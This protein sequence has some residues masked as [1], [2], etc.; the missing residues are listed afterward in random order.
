MT[1][2]AGLAMMGIFLAIG[3]LLVSKV[4]RAC[5]SIMRID[6]ALQEWKRQSGDRKDRP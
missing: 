5:D 3:F 6:Q 4:S 1:D 2:I